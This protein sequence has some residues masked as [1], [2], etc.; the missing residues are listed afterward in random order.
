MSA[1]RIATS[2]LTLAALAVS[3]ALLPASPALAEKFAALMIDYQT[4]RVLHAVNADAQRYP[5]SL[6]KMMTLYMAFDALRD[7][8]ISLSQSMP[9]SAR[10]AA[11]DPSKLGLKAGETISVE[12]AVLGLA[13][14]SANDAAVVLAEFLGG[15]EPRF[16]ELMTQQARQLG[17][18]RTT[19]QNASGLPDPDQVTT[20][21]DM[22]T[23]GKALIR[24]FPAYYRFFNTR[25]FTYEGRV[26]NNHN[27]M[28]R[29]FEGADGIK[30][31][32]I[33]ASGFNLV[34][35]AQRD[36]RRLIGV[37]FGGDSPR[38][39]D[40][41]M[42]RMLERGFTMPGRGDDILV[43]DAGI[44]GAPA[45]KP[46]GRPQPAQARQSQP[47]MLASSKIAQGDSEDTKPARSARPAANPLGDGNRVANA[48]TVAMA[49][50]VARDVGTAPAAGSGSGS[51][52][53]SGWAIQVGAFAANG[54][55]RS[56]AEQAIKT[57]GGMLNRGSILIHPGKGANGAQV[58]R[59]RIGGLSESQ[60]RDACRLLSQRQTSC[61]ALSPSAL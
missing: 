9:V 18:S 42:A 24:D 1:K 11:Q 5:A 50:P 3:A 23:L 21:R 28:L 56:A 59:A 15:T 34:A 43:A 2:T 44:D 14:K 12:D 19:F 52:Q 20:A 4:G 41:Q 40:D 6:T 60:A 57:A 36:G 51:V 29:N 39:R 48:Q 55:A 22:A 37:I 47:Q 61:F 38:R 8:R 26:H 53:G 45:A 32:F 17:M 27:H 16:A 35:S 30:T 10:A 58:F 49:A 31:G 13:T 7:K 33:R 25:S 46:S 54:A